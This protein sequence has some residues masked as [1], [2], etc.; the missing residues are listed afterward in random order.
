[1][2][3]SKIFFRMIVHLSCYRNEK[4]R[5]SAVEELEKLTAGNRAKLSAGACLQIG[6]NRNCEDYK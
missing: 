5:A 2:N 1:M 6:G 3:R 4:P